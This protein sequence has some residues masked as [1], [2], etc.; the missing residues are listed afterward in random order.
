M[1]GKRQA[2]STAA[3][4]LQPPAAAGL[5]GAVGAAAADANVTL[6]ATAVVCP[7]APENSSTNAWPPP[8]SRSPHQLTWR[9]PCGFVAN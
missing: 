9:G 4:F 3:P 1:T 8:G 5:V 7:V 2:L 6:P